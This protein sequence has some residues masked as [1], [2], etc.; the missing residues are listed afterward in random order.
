MA[1][2]KEGLHIHHVNGMKR[3]NSRKN[4]RVLCALC[5]RDVDAHHKTMNIKPDI[6]RY[7]TLHRAY[8]N[9]NRTEATPERGTS[10]DGFVYNSS[11]KV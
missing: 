1:D 11:H 10:D 3:D 8:A 2:K 5:H 9:R 6:E 7:I 4:L